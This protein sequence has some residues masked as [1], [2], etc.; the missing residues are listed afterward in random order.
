MTSP[1]TT[2]GE[3]LPLDDRKQI[4][5]ICDRFEARWREG[6]RPDLSPFLDGA[7]GPARARLFRE[8]LALER[9]LRQRDGERPGPGTYRERFPDDLDV[10]DAVFTLGGSGDATVARAPDPDATR[11]GPGPSRAEP[12][13]GIGRALRAA[14]YVVEHELGRGGMGVVY[15]ASQSSLNR[16]VALKVIRSG[17]FATESESRRFRNEAEAVAQ[18]D[19][20]HIVPI[21]DVGESLGLPFFSMKL[22]AGASLDD[23][24][25]AYRSDPRAAARVVA[26]VAGAVH[27]AHQRGILHR[28]LKP[29]NIL[30]DDRDAPYVT[31]FGLAR[32]IEGDGNQTHPG[33]IVGTPSYMSPEQ[34]SGAKQPLTTATDVYGL[35]SIL[36][37]LLSGRA[38]HSGSSLIE[39][40]DLVRGMAPEPPSKFNR[41]VP[42]DLEVICLKCLEKEPHRRYPDAQALADDLSRW[43]SGM[44]IAARPV[45]PATRAWSWCRRHPLPAVLAA[46]LGVSLLGGLAGVSWKWR[47]AERARL[48]SAMLVDYLTNRVL[49][50]SSTAVNPRGAGFTVLEMLDRSAAR[51]GGDFQGQPEVEAAIRETVGGSYLS[52]GEF[53]QAETHLRAAL[54]LD[55]ELFGPE[56]PATLHVVN[57]LAALFEESGRFAEAEPLLRRNLEACRRALGPEDVTTLAAMDQLGALLRARQRREEAEPLL[58]TALAARRRV[59]PTDDPETLRSVRNLCL[60]MVDENRY[61]E[62]DTLA[63]EY[64]HG[65]RCAWG[66]KH[67]DNVAA[68]ANRGL[69]RLLQGRPDQ[70]EAYYRQAVE[71][72]RRILGPDHPL[73][74]AAASDLARV[75]RDIDARAAGFPDDPFAP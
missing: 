44:P 6:E 59:L 26:L 14:G 23:R 25:D 1:A 2:D 10:I 32:R 75:L 73:T 3:T 15:R 49:A 65:I 17:G 46:M 24:L 31:D 58:R 54:K 50:E 16:T 41:R 5:A 74:K 11:D 72:A 63:Q 45:G 69:I 62:A 22:I 39:T 34:A 53:A 20:P 40:L 21:Y 60:L 42:R 64:E 4:D 33:L 7:T 27:H 57:V 30:V 55:A 8:L 19:H 43:L 67:P 35:G 47:E 48:K 9:E 28:D 36:Y 68:L 13:D 29:A 52:L 37:A 56:H 66:P 61:V 51:I 12:G 71:E 38:P 18:L 70:A